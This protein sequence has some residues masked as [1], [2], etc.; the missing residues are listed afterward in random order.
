MTEKVVD[1]DVK[2]LKKL[3]Q[4]KKKKK[5][6]NNVISLFP[7]AIPADGDWLDH[8][9]PVLEKRMQK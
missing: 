6:K 7:G 2:S 8:V 3:K 9:K 5:I 1:W 4:K